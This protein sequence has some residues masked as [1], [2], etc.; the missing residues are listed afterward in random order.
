MIDEDELNELMKDERR[1]KL[2]EVARDMAEERE[3]TRS[4]YDEGMRDSG[5]CEKDFL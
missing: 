5:M 2:E 4:D 1:A 3:E